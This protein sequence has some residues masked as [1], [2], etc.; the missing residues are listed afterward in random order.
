[1]AS[2]RHLGCVKQATRIDRFAIDHAAL[3][4]TVVKRD[5]TAV[6]VRDNGREHPED[7]FGM[8]IGDFLCKPAD[9]TIGSEKAC[10]TGA[11]NVGAPAFIL[12]SL[13]WE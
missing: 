5:A 8:F 7:R 13:S 4:L 1:M 2:G 11:R 12:T 10:C 6:R 9:A 3:V